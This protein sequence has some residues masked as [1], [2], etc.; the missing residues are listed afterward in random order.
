MSLIEKETDRKLLRNIQPET[1]KITH[2]SHLR[3]DD[4]LRNN[5]V[6]VHRRQPVLPPPHFHPPPEYRRW[7]NPLLLHRPAFHQLLKLRE[8][9]PRRLQRTQLL[10]GEI[11][12]QVVGDRRQI[13]GALLPRQAPVHS[14]VGEGGGRVLGGGSRRRL[15]GRRSWSE[16]R[17]A[18]GGH[19]EAGTAALL[20]VEL[21]APLV[22]VGDGDVLFQAVDV[23]VF[24]LQLGNYS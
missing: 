17:R 7:G 21:D 10:A 24:G 22:A 4:D 23:G 20:V 3:S 13:D 18:R 16:R 2:P 6:L 9:E 19:R 15:G 8:R 14:E 5:N 11:Q 12:R 1:N